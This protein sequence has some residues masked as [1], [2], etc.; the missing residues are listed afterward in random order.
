MACGGAEPAP[1]S[2]P[3]ADA[4]RVDTSVAGISADGSTYEGAVPENPPIKLDGD[5]ACAREH[6]N[7]MTLDNDRS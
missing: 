5:P 3:P 2:A 6:P 7:G 4:K 1:A